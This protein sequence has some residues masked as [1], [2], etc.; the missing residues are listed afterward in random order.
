MTSPDNIRNRLAFMLT[1]AFVVMVPL[2]LFKTFPEGNKD[3]LTY[4]VGQLSGMAL[5]AIGHYF[6]NRAGQD[7]IDEKRVETTQAAF[8]AVEAQANA[9]AT[10]QADTV[11]VTADTANVET[12]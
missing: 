5:M 10:Q 2:F 1:G 7:A 6:T 3:I 8:R 9:S 12:K 4:M 11:N